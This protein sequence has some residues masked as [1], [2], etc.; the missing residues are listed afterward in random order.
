MIITAISGHILLPPGDNSCN[1]PAGQEIQ[2]QQECL[3]FSVKKSMFAKKKKNPDDKRMMKQNDNKND[4][5]A[6]V[7]GWGDSLC[8]RSPS[9]Q[10]AS[11]MG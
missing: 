5:S 9:C 11:L 10:P 4:K 8:H 7:A 3:S 1:A 6:Q 2:M